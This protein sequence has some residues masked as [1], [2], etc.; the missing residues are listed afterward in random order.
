MS[1]ICQRVV[2]FCKSGQ[3]LP[4]LVP[5]TVDSM[6]P[7]P[8]CHK[9]SVNSYKVK[10]VVQLLLQL[11]VC[12]PLKKNSFGVSLK[13]YRLGLNCKNNQSMYYILQLGSGCGSVGRMFASN[14]RDSRFESSQMQ[15]IRIIKILNE[16]I[17]GRL[18]LFWL[19][20]TQLINLNVHIPIYLNCGLNIHLFI[21]AKCTHTTT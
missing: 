18:E 4:N 20:N 15:I 12:E 21:S 1:K 19:A 6:L 2:N 17:Y 10:G 3:I 5:L 8:R 11:I 16:N 14:T 13:N 7:F 9:L